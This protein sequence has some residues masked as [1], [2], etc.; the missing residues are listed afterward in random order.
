MALQLTVHSTRASPLVC[1][2]SR[3]YSAALLI[4]PIPLLLSFYPAHTTLTV[5][6]FRTAQPVLRVASS[7]WVGLV[8]APRCGV[9]L[10]AI[11]KRMEKK[12]SADGLT[13]DR[14]CAH[15]YHVIPYNWY[16]SVTRLEGDMCY[17][18]SPGSY[19]ADGDCK[20]C[21]LGRYQNDK[22]QSSCSACPAGRYTSSVFGSIACEV[23]PEGKT[24]LS[25]RGYTLADCFKKCPEGQ[26]GSKEKDE[27]LSCNPGTY[28]NQTAGTDECTACERKVA[29]FR[30]P[31][32]LL[33]M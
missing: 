30:K 11:K 6:D 13:C 31:A 25:G 24:V 8:F 2:T 5:L 17:T 33:C 19:F 1:K 18:C 14:S 12:F 20:L 4:L 7:R 9:A 15:D 3:P 29:T 16:G 22:G 21:P 32:V 27:C 23:C 28:N 26:Y 10:I